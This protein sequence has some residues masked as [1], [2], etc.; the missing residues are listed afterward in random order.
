MNLSIKGFITCKGAELYSDCADYY[1][2]NPD[3]HSFCISDGV[4]KSFFPKLWSKNICDK[5]VQTE[6][7]DNFQFIGEA[8]KQWQSQIEEIIAQPHV[9]W[10]TKAQYNKRSPALA[11]FVGLEFVENDLKWKAWALGDSFLFF[12]PKN[13]KDFDG[14][15]IKLSSKQE[16]IEFDNFPDYYSS[17]GKNHKGDLQTFEGKLE[18]GTFFLMTDA[19]AEW[20]ISGK[21][22]A[23]DIANTWKDQIEFEDYVAT[24]RK[25]GNLTDDDSAILI[26]KLESTPTGVLV[27]STTEIT[28]LEELIQKQELEIRGTEPLELPEE[29]NVLSAEAESR[30]EF[31]KEETNTPSGFE[32]TTE[33]PSE[34][35]ELLNEENVPTSRT[36]LGQG[37][38]KVQ[39]VEIIEY[40][41]VQ[42]EMKKPEFP[43]EETQEE[44]PRQENSIT[45]KRFGKMALSVNQV[46]Y[47]AGT[48]FLN[49]FGESKNS[50]MEQEPIVEKNNEKGEI[51]KNEAV[52]VT[53]IES[54]ENQLDTA[55][56]D[57]E[58]AELLG[59]I[60]EVEKKEDNPTCES[61]KSEGLIESE[62]K[63]ESKIQ[64]EVESSITQEKTVREN[65][66][67]TNEAAKQIT[68][69]F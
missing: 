65:L 67:P 40:E 21:E 69:K 55:E 12:V 64:K 46:L 18:E 16:P 59:N 3:N 15:V 10:Y 38:E 36:E 63:E 4:S 2:S 30:E 49:I 39:E 51:I 37:A 56:K 23:I 31:G 25:N 1:S 47:E 52:Q 41:L 27:Y 57:G 14:E 66:K 22:K 58:N 54:V 62:K 5:F 48:I 17:I 61:E 11:T 29:E 43:I 26:M 50:E 6:V 44:I 28:S 34:P 24:E 68:N 20:F 19:L 45:K 8:Q 7:K 42:E 9:K 53:E 32:E 35:S 60:P 13:Y 33:P